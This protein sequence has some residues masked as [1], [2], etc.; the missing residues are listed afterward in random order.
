MKKI[1]CIA[2]ALLF[3]FSSILTVSA[4]EVKWLAK[5]Q[6]DEIYGSDE[7]GGIIL[8]KKGEK[9]GYIDKNG[10]ALLDFNYDY[11]T[12]FSKG[13]AYVEKD[14]NFSYIDKNGK[15]LFNLEAKNYLNNLKYADAGTY[16]FGSEFN[17]DYAIVTSEV[18][19]SFIIDR[20]GKYVSVPAGVLVQEY[21]INNN[22]AIIR[23]ESSSEIGYL[24]IKTGKTLFSPHS[25]TDFDNGYGIVDYGD[26]NIGVVDT[27]LEYVNKKIHV[28]EASASFSNG[29]IYLGEYTED[30]EPLNASYI[31]I[32][33]KTLIPKNYLVL[34]DYQ[35]GLIAA[36]II[37][38]DISKIGYLDIKGNW[39]IKPMECSSYSGFFKGIAAFSKTFNEETYNENFGLI[40][41]TGKFVLQPQFQDFSFDKH[42]AYA[43]V[44]GLWG[45]LNL[46]GLVNNGS[47]VPNVSNDKPDDWAVAEVTK[48]IENNLVPT[49]LQNNYK[50]KITR[51]DFCDLAISLVESI[52]GK[53]IDAILSDKGLSIAESPFSD[54]SSKN[55]LAAYKLSIVNGKGNGLFDPNGYITRQEAAVMLT[56][57]AKALGI[58]VNSKEAVFAD[59]KSI[60]SWAKNA[61]NYVSSNNVM[62]GTNA[63]FEPKANYTRQQAYITI[64]RLFDAIK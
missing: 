38:N 31:D 50:E 40:D 28:G 52:S 34:G 43:K 41:K 2:L 5:P 25:V 12:G 61:V 24:N 37:E 13:I 48:S 58:D 1:L 20:A 53:N 63:G 16:L 55:I 6:F 21:E 47:N 23:K 15:V 49:A 26:G 32:N 7:E 45:I 35:D 27:N 62:K 59:S 11:A 44:D 10:K 64:F 4:E 18:G 46:D 30:Y 33:G 56:N 17:G 3:C 51:K 14:G 54:T 19:E 29:I 22:I 8:A 39:V 42:Y 36:N 57:T 9:Y 60:D